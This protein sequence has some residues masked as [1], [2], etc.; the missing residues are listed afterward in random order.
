M[1]RAV[2]LMKGGSGGTIKI[3]GSAQL[4][5]QVGDKVTNNQQLAPNSAFQG[6]NNQQKTSGSGEDKNVCFMEG[7]TGGEIDIG[8]DANLKFHVGDEVTNNQQQTSSSQATYIAVGGDLK[9]DGD[10]NVNAKGRTQDY[11]GVTA[12]TINHGEITSKQDNCTSSVNVQKPAS[13]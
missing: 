13:K 5:V 10:M 1:A 3:G 8:E 7:T 2:S 6:T 12:H 4:N 11:T 9:V